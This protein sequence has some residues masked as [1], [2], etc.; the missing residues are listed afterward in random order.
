VRKHV[1]R[2]HGVTAAGGYEE[3]KAQS[4]LGGR[5]AVYWR[6]DLEAKEEEVDKGVVGGL[7]CRFGLFGGGWGDKLPKSW[8]RE[9]KVVEDG[10]PNGW[11]SYSKE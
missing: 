3:V 7:E 1:N 4:W 2:E 10:A 9:G 6:V 11:F 8:P 5:R